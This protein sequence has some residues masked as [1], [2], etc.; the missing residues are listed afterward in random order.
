MAMFRS[1]VI[2]TDGVPWLDSGREMSG[3]G[4]PQLTALRG[5]SVSVSVPGKA[6]D[7]EGKGMMPPPQSLKFRKGGQM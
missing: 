2:P 4:Q 6:S 3:E 7:K 1:E 5:D